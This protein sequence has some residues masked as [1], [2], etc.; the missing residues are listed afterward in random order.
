MA[1]TLGSRSDAKNKDSQLGSCTY[2]T[3]IALLGVETT[4]QRIMF[5][6]LEQDRFHFPNSISGPTENVVFCSE[7]FALGH[8]NR[9]IYNNAKNLFCNREQALIH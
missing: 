4:I 2:F 1:L 5:F 9:F 3:R 8:I 6:F 7:H